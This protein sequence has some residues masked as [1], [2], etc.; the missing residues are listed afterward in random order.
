MTCHGNVQTDLFQ[1]VAHSTSQLRNLPARAVNNCENS[2]FWNLGLLIRM[3]RAIRRSSKL[4]EFVEPGI[5]KSI[6]GDRHLGQ[7]LAAPALNL[8]ETET[9]QRA[10]TRHLNHLK[11]LKLLQPAS[12]GLSVLWWTEVEIRRWGPFL[13]LCRGV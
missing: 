10:H 9:R 11:K 1:K 5:A 8:G 3:T 7:L 12:S 2:N 6:S 13:Y 4:L